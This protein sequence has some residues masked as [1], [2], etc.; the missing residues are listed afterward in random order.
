MRVFYWLGCIETKKNTSTLTCIG[1]KFAKNKIC[2]T[3][4]LTYNPRTRPFDIRAMTV[5]C[6]YYLLT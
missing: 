3:Y 4:C 1:V 5:Y 6:Q 2:K